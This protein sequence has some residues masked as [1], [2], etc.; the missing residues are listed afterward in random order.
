MSDFP[1]YNTKKLSIGKTYDLNDP[2]DRR[3]YFKDKMGDKIEELK[4][5]LDENTFVGFLVAKKSAG[6][7]TYSK[8]FQEVIGSERVALV[9]VG[10]V[11]RK[12]HERALGDS[13]YKKELYAYLEENYRSTMPLEEAFDAFINRSQDKLIPTEFVLTLL[14]KEIDTIGRKGIFIDGFPRNFDQVSYSLYLRD[15]INY[16]DDPDFF[17]LID[18]PETVIDARIK[19]RVVCPKCKTSRSVSLL[20]TKFIGYDAKE[21]DYYLICDN[22][23]CSGYKKQRLVAKEGD[24]AGIKSIR[25]RLDRDG[26]LIEYTQEIYGIPK[27]LIRNTI[28]LD[29]ADELVEDYEITPRYS[30]DGNEESGIEIKEE[31]WVTEDDEGVKSVSL[32]AASTVLSMID[33]IHSILLG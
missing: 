5:Y 28:P 27:V 25:E 29:K 23:E 9:S 32:L 24:A 2:V 33:Q 19:A 22:K 30:Y 14:K 20:P 10:D 11:I 31:P 26:K 7:G 12:A 6:K 3:K 15:L 13:E 4:T 1:F 8:L 21:D 18:V 16:R 17:V